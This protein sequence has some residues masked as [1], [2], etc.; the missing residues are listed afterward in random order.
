M[1]L[2]FPFLPSSIVVLMFLI[3]SLLLD[4]FRHNLRSMDY[5]KLLHVNLEHQSL[6]S[7]VVLLTLYFSLL[8]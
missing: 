6:V 7:L 8:F 4:R 3:L 5:F 1:L 2:L